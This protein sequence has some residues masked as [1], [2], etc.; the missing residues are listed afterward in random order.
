ML[1]SFQCCLSPALL[2]LGGDEDGIPF[3]CCVCTESKTATGDDIGGVDTLGGRGMEM[4]SGD[5]FWD[6][7]L[8]FS[9][10]AE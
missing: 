3:H 2:A 1:Y 5:S 10:C 7:F 4:I 9:G 8:E 6:N